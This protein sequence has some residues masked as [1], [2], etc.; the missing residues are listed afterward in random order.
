VL[1]K[2][3]YEKGKAQ[4]E[5]SDKVVLMIMEN[6]IDPTIRG[7]LPKNAENA[8]T[9][10]AKIEE[11][12]QGS[13]KAN[14]SILMSKMMQA[15]YDGRGN[16]REHILKMINISNKLKDLEC[17]LPD[18]YVIHYIM[19]SLPPVLEKFKINY[20][21]SDKKWTMAELIAKLS[22]EEERLR[23]ENDRHLV[24]F[25][26]GSSSGHEKLGGKF[27]HQKRKGKKPY[28]PQRKLLRKMPLMERKVPSA[29]ILRN[30]GT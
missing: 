26:K 8:K 2:A 7:A 3:D 25:I 17:P 1:Q 19:M 10:M 16:V 28:D 11:H 13:S 23:T 18:P 4:W 21:S 30:M 5:R 12:F 22:Q 9:F 14:V 20:N 24:N 15:K 27:S 6:A 29:A